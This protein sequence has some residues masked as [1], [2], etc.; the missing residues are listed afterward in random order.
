MGCDSAAFA[1]QLCAVAERVFFICNTG[2]D[3]WQLPGA[4]KEVAMPYHFVEASYAQRLQELA[5]SYAVRLLEPKADFLRSNV[6]LQGNTPLSKEFQG[7][8]R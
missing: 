4:R 6:T 3:S 5:A 1:R 8:S 2:D 7:E